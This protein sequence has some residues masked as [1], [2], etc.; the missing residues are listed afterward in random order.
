MYDLCFNEIVAT[1][2]I[3][4]FKDIF[5]HTLSDLKEIKALGCIIVA[6]LGVDNQE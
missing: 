5:I 3:Q 1:R 4:D 2:M 6:V